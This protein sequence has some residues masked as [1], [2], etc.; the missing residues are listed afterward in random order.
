MGD[1]P[2]NLLGVDSRSSNKIL[3]K[4]KIQRPEEIRSEMLAARTSN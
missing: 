2:F 4:S 1:G 3:G